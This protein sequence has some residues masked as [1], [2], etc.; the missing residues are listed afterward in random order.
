MNLNV[1]LNVERRKDKRSVTHEQDL[2]LVYIY[3][4]KN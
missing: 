2:V 1:E 4:L 3:L